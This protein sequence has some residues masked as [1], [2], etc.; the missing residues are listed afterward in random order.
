M[1]NIL[2]TYPIQP[3]G[4]LQIIV[5][6]IL[7]GLGINACSLAAPN[8]PA[9]TNQEQL[10]ISFLDVGEGDATLIRGSEIQ[11]TLIDSGNLISG[12]IL[13]QQLS[14][15]G[16]MPIHNLI[17]THPHP[18]H[19]GGV[20]ALNG[21]QP[22]LAIFDN[23]QSLDKELRD[24]LYRWYKELVRS[25]DSYKVLTRGDSLNL[26]PGLSIKTLWPEAPLDSDWNSNSLV[27]QIVA[28]EK[29]I[30]I[31]GD[32]NEVSERA[33]TNLDKE[34]LSAHILRAGHHGSARTGTQPFINFVNADTIIVS[35]NANNYSG[36]PAPSVM[37]RYRA[38][39][40][41]VLETRVHGNI[42]MRWNGDKFSIDT[43]GAI[44]EP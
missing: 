23:G 36:Y 4:R 12:S 10:V 2:P 6:S 3:A 14:R 26:G 39:K 18:D 24:P 44:C 25:H 43:G 19:M 27:L 21:I 29:R 17:L 11:T 9:A 13:A 20:F 15:C 5:L 41:Q 7:F 40:A 16:L 33:I 38:S 42:H 8:K 1:R 22:P 31:M 37:D 32:A 28:K 35:V 30:L 34:G